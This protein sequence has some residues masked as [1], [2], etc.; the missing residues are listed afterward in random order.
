MRYLIMKRSQARTLM[1]ALMVVLLFVVLAALNL[2]LHEFGH[3]LTM[4]RVGG[5]CEGVYLP[6]GFKVWPLAEFG[7]EFDQ[8]WDGYIALTAYGPQRLPLEEPQYGLVS[9]MGSG[10]TAILAV[11]ALAA[12]YLVRPRGWGEKAL[13]FQALFFAD[14]LLYTIL[15]EW[16][17]LRH[18]FFV[19]GSTPEPLDGA[20]QMGITRGGFIAGVLIFSLLMSAA[21]VGYLFFRT[22]GRRSTGQ[23]R[24]TPAN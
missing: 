15:P 20:V 4:E 21:W 9:L 24:P 5:E 2:L 16:F 10:T 18:F 8:E 7:G 22:A 13:L 14:L 17:G 6:P 19:G 23:V 1:T 11:I 12:L 3:C